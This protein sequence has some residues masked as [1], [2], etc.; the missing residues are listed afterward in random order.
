MIDSGLF[1]VDPG[2]DFP[3]ALVQGFRARMQAVAP[4]TSARAVVYLN[5]AR[6]RDRVHRAFLGAGPGFI[7]R[8]RLVTDLAG[9]IAG[10]GFQRRLELA[11]SVRSLLTRMPDLA[12]REA[13]FSLADSL[14][15]LFEEMHGEG[16]DSAVLETLSLGDHSG[17]WER[18]LHFL[19]L[20]QTYL[21]PLS[22]PD[23]QSALRMAVMST[24]AI[25]A[26][27][28]PDHPVI[29]AGSTGSRGTTRLLMEAVARLPMGAVVLPGFDF[30]MPASAWPHLSADHPQ[31]RFADLAAALGV[32]PDHMRRWADLA[33]PDPARNRLVSLALRPAPVTD[34]WITEGPTLGDLRLALQNV[35]LIEA[36]GPR[37]EAEA[38]A[39]LMHQ[40][41]GLGLRVA[42]ITPDRD[43]S[44]RV[45]GALDRVQL[46]PDDSAGRPLSQT[47]PG[48]FLRQVGH[49]LVGRVTADA[50]IAL[51]KHPLCHSGPGRNTHLL[52][53]RRL[54]I[55]LRKK[56]LGFPDLTRLAAFATQEGDADWLTWIGAALMPPAGDIRP[57]T[58]WIAAHL[59]LVRHLAR[60]ESELWADVAGERARDFLERLL[61]A[62]DHGGEMAV[63]D[64]LAML[65]TYMA[66]ET[67]RDTV[68]TD[69]NLMIWGT[70]EARAQ[71]ADL[72]ILGGLNEG[73]WPASAAPDPWLNRP[74]RKEAGLLL[75]ERQIGLSAHDFQQAVAA[76]QVILTRAMRDADAETVPSRWLNRLVNLASGLTAQHGPQALARARAQ[77]QEILHRVRARE[78]DHA[79]LAPDITQRNP[80][81]APMPPENARPRRLRVTEIQTLIR[82]PFQ[83]YARHVLGLQPLDSLRAEPDARDF[84]TAL[85]H[86]MERFTE[87]VP[88]GVLASI[89]TYLGLVLTALRAEIPDEAPRILALARV[90][91]AAPD[92]LDWHAEQ[93]AEAIQT[94]ETV[95]WKLE[96]PVFELSGRAD[97]IDLLADDGVALF[98]YKSGQLPTK[99]VQKHFD[100]QLV[101]LAL[102]MRA[103]AF[104]KL[105]PREVRRAEF[106]KIA[107]AFK[108]VAAPVAPADLDQEEK[109]LLALLRSYLRPGQGFTARR[110]MK[111]DRD[112]S[113]F[114][115]LARRGEWQVTDEAESVRVG[116]HDG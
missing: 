102:M 23:P 39:E 78:A 37:E 34:R 116:D 67:V 27:S 89:E 103:G 98:D 68:E 80:R 12:P 7:P 110:A 58:G 72:V 33:P 29:V 18:S 31:A 83:I 75:P 111:A 69:R 22:D 86:A 16:V 109:R 55:W 30:D 94:E 19:R 100:K 35:T 20:V 63:G 82:D 8:L 3:L 90:L 95:H 106:V 114:D 13:A 11:Q 9:D 112:N 81:P 28:P 91:S 88:A 49:L 38:V 15:S 59:D 73:T 2:V 41:Q 52:R 57:L 1:G 14:S 43:L 50:L 92:L 5:T 76:P 4:E 32:P 108:T 87:Q 44:R 61:A 99:K 60:D 47:A 84:G 56:R 21:D 65:E 26:V 48:R 42:L 66:A 85:H 51:L 25:W 17:H 79:H 70:L 96:N 107:S 54:D 64:Y 104:G 101:L 45:A 24:C 93:L 105:G 74:M 53:T 77:G 115:H 10:N 6:M 71:G 36:P 62:A 113:D 97:R 40:A 46:R